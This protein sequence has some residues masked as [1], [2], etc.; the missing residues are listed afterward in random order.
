MKFSIITPTYNS[1]RT[2]KRTLESILFQTNKAFEHIIVDGLSTDN[3]LKII[4][5]YRKD[6]IELGINLEIISEED[7]GVYDAMNKG[8]YKSSGDWIWI[9]N[10]DDFL[11]RQAIE[12]VKTNALKDFCY[13]IYGNINLYSYSGE[14]IGKRIPKGMKMAYREMPLFHPACIVSRSAYNEIGVFNL[15]YKLSADYDWLLRFLEKGLSYT[16]LD[17]I[18]SNY[19]DGGLSTNNIFLSSW[20]SFNVRIRN[21]Q[22]AIFSFFFFLKIII[23]AFF[24]RFVRIVKKAYKK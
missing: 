14:K 11:Q 23:S 17:E 1:E 8:I 15:N 4:E 21:G 18:L 22:P 7:F 10:S 24:V 9:V 2:I 5:Y 12:I 16:Y 13:M 20:E 3:T 19:S 6:Y